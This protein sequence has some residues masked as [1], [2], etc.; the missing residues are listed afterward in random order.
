MI[1]R[2]LLDLLF[3]CKVR[4][5]RGFTV[6]VGEFYDCSFAYAPFDF[7]ISIYDNEG[8]G[9]YLSHKIIVFVVGI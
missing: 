1:V 8:S 9:G 2:H 5:I 3:A 7:F 4:L 6:D